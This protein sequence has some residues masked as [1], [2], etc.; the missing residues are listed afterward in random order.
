MAVSN[1]G[2]DPEHLQGRPPGCGA[3]VNRLVYGLER[4][5]LRLKLADDGRKVGD[6]AR[7]PVNA[8]ENA[9]TV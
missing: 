1:S 6:A 3:C 7:Q 5:A 9:S 8:G 4:D 2:E